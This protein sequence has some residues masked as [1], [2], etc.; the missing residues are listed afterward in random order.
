MSEL[1][2]ITLTG[3]PRRTLAEQIKKIRDWDNGN[4]NPVKIFINDS[5][6]QAEASISEIEEAIDSDLSTFIRKK[7]SISRNIDIKTGGKDDLYICPVGFDPKHPATKKIR[8]K[9][10]HLIPAKKK[11][12]KAKKT[13]RK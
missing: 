12:K 1:A 9:V 5:D 3:V 13:H 4:N 8:N 11:R 6:V 10:L 7:F 2:E